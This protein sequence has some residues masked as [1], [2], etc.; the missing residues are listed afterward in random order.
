MIICSHD[1]TMRWPV[2]V[3][4][5]SASA[6]CFHSWI[7]YSGV[8]FRV[9]KSVS[10]HDHLYLPKR[11]GILYLGTCSPI[12][13]KPALRPKIIDRSSRYIVNVIQYALPPEFVRLPGLVT[14][15]GLPCETTFWP[16]IINALQKPAPSWPPHCNVA[17]SHRRR[18]GDHRCYPP[19]WIG[20]YGV[21]FLFCCVP[22]ASF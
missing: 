3:M 21:S 7:A 8:L 22:V 9:E 17:T 16:Y 2:K 13:T 20:L 6:M 10:I 19:R 18:Q 15:P 5:G 12:M 4:R 11:G 14:P 1:T